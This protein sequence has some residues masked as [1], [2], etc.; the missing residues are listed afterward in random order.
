MC[1]HSWLFDVGAGA[2]TQAF[3]LMQ[4][5]EPSPQ[6]LPWN[7]ALWISGASGREVTE[8]SQYFCL[9]LIRPCEGER[10]WRRLR[11]GEIKLV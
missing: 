2:Q 11:F 4:Q 5:A 7:F 1:L 10:C 3:M 6:L 8:V 9:A